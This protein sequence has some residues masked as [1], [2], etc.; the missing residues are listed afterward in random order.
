MRITTLPVYSR[1][2]NPDEI[3]DL[4]AL[5]KPPS[6]LH[7]SQHQV[8]TLRALRDPNVDVIFNTAMTGDGKSLAAQIRTLLE[9]L[10]LLVMYPTNELIRD[11]QKQIERTMRA[12]NKQLRIEPLYGDRL[13]KMVN[14]NHE[15]TTKA[16]AIKRLAD[17]N[18]VIFT[19]P[20]I[21]H[22][23]AEFYYTR[24]N[25]TPDRL[26]ARTLV[27]NFELYVFD[28]FHIFQIPQIV[29]ML[30]ALLLIREVAGSQFRK[31][32]LFLSA[33]PIDLL[34]E[35]FAKA[36][37]QIA[38]IRGEYTHTQ[39]LPDLQ[40]WRPILRASQITFYA[41]KIETWIDSHLDDTLLGFYKRQHP[42]AK[43][44][45]I[46]NS[47][48][49]AHRLAN[50]IAPH[51]AQEGLTVA[52]NTGLTG[53]ETKRIS[54]DADLLIATSTVDV[55]VD[56]RI[57]FLVFE[58]RDSGTFLQ[59]LGRLGRHSDDG[60][61]HTFDMFEAHAIVPKFVA[62]RLF[63]GKGEE[64]PLLVDDGEFTREDLRDAITVAYPTPTEFRSYAR[65]WGGLQSASV[66]YKLGAPPV[67]ETYART[68][69]RLKELYSTTFG[70]SI[71]QQMMWLKEMRENGQTKLVE[72]AMSFRGE[73]PFACGLIDTTEQGVQRIKE[74]D[75]FRLAPNFE[76]EF[77][78]FDEFKQEASHAGVS[79]LPPRYEKF[80]A[81]FRLL[82]ATDKRRAMMIHINDDVGFWGAEQF[83]IASIVS[84]IELD[85]AGVPWVS[86]VNNHLHRREFVALLC[87]CKPDDLRYRLRLPPMFE[88]YP[89]TARDQT[90][91]T[92]CFARDALL[93]HVAIKEK[94]FACGGGAMI[95]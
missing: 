47:V 62:E 44:A 35:Y 53:E 3:A 32:F 24:K 63:I 31:K 48:A 83:G 89:F 73:S 18:E 5:G 95:I 29:S 41:D 72:E 51:F 64:K 75:L 33:T 77:L 20:D 43:G 42:N 90:Q 92:I 50:R 94:R 28:E 85:V 27:D 80:V 76:L 57:N 11:Q 87:L 23:I 93:L 4:I 52:L 66:Y 34:N 22:Y 8:D 86:E 26:F 21:F 78:S 15:H 14:E 58:S 46:V 81:H 38:R 40:K 68:R 71:L 7:L 6:D 91:G 12:W 65:E 79:R 82:G 84:R 17:N 1:L 56:F 88:L 54:Y 13:D 49:T 61:G 55:G 36:N 30:N 37:F 19:N 25:D 45:I 67:K 10:P 59:R 39:T 2:S 60:H 70:I 9:G 16:D 74:N 69:E